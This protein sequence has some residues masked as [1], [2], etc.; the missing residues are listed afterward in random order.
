MS[1]MN[2]AIAECRAL[3]KYRL[4]LRF[5]DGSV[6]EVDL[7]HLVGSGVFSAWSDPTFFQRVVIDAETG[8]VC[9]PGGIDLDPYVL[10]SKI[11]GKPLPMTPALV[12]PR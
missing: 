11:T 12:P 5:A 4:W 9:W 6:G 3:P 10:Y 8:T 1:R 2:I 7:S